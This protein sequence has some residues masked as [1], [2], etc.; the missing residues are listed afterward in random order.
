MLKRALGT[1]AL[2]LSL[3][4]AGVAAAAG[5]GPLADDGGDAE[6][7]D[8]ARTGWYLQAGFTYGSARKLDDEL[9]QNADKAVAPATCMEGVPPIPGPPRIPAVQP[10]CDPLVFSVDSLSDGLGFNARI[11][12]RFLPHLSVEVQTEYMNGFDVKLVGAPDVSVDALSFSVNLRVPLLTGRVQPYGLLGGGALW[13]F[14]D[15]DFPYRAILYDAESESG[16]IEFEEIVDADRVGAQV[17]MGAG[18]DIYVT[19]HVVWT[20]EIAWVTTLGPG[21]NDL[22]YLA[23]GTGF[24][25]RF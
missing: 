1:C 11:G 10:T 24:A 9:R 3:C 21:V 13:V 18:L 8:Y 6:A 16:P 12:R 23:L 25:Y 19:E 4:C 15:R 7:V 17:R 20:G 14:K 22:K 2:S 5:E